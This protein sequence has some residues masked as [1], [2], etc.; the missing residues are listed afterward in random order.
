MSQAPC[1]LFCPRSGFTPPPGLPRL[2][3]IMAM[4][5]SAITPSV[6]VECSV[7]PR[8][9]TMAAAPAPPYIF[10]AD[11]RSRWSMPQISA[12]RAGV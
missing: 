8:Q 11:T 2:P 12:T 3:V 9:Y 5:E 10:A 6:P 7:T 1:T 4:F